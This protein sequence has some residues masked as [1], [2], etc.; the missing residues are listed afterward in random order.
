MITNMVKSDPVVEEQVTQ[1]LVKMDEE[2]EYLNKK[3]KELKDK[4]KPLPECVL[5]R[6]LESETIP[7][8]EE[9]KTEL[10]SLVTKYATF[11]HE[12]Q[13]R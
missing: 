10:V 9:Y 7:K 3:A 2:I 12:K 13:D 4:R 11:C 8:V 5:S 6:E 1:I